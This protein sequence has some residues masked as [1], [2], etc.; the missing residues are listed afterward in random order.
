M[1]RHRGRRADESLSS[2]SSR[3]ESEASNSDSET[4]ISSP[5][6]SSPS[7]HEGCSRG[8]YVGKRRR[9]PAS[10]SNSSSESD[11]E[12][13]G[14]CARQQVRSNKIRLRKRSKDVSTIIEQANQPSYGSSS[15]SSDTDRDGYSTDPDIQSDD[16]SSD[17]EDDGYADGTKEIIARMRERW[18][19]CVK[20]LQGK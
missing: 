2:S 19:R 14:I 1:V 3:I 11:D 9:T 18:E 6:S 20:L 12:Y 16:T 10:S 8:S 4:E 13:G 5:E 17:S 7:F 15:G